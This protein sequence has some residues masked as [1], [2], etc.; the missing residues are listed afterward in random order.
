MGLHANASQVSITLAVSVNAMSPVISDDGVGIE[1]EEVRK[2][3][4]G[5]SMLS[6][7]ERGRLLNGAVAWRSTPRGGTEVTAW[8]PLPTKAA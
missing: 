7:Q 5:L 6:I 8:L 4:A 2:R 1:L 3:K